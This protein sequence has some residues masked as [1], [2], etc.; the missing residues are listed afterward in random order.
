MGPFFGTTARVER[1]ALSPNLEIV[2]HK[3]IWDLRFRDCAV[4]L[5]SNLLIL[6]C[7]FAWYVSDSVILQNTV[8]TVLGC[9]RVTAGM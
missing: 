4:E 3:D 8:E 2:S 1:Q 9:R 6:R 7:I 5:V